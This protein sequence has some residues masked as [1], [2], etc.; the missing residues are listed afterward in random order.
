MICRNTRS[1][2]LRQTK[3]FWRLNK[4]YMIGSGLSLL[5]QEMQFE[6]NREKHFVKT[7]NTKALCYQM[8][9]ILCLTN[10]RVTTFDHF[11]NRQHFWWLGA[12]KHTKMSRWKCSNIETEKQVRLWWQ[13]RC[14]NKIF[15][16]FSQ[17]EFN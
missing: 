6:E 13:I 12:N 15:T 11:K 10:P 4:L 5:R 17:I 2:N 14:F 8:K 7:N 9:H 16:L 1:V 3:S